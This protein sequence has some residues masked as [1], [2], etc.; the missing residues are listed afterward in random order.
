MLLRRLI[1]LAFTLAVLGTTAWAVDARDDEYE[2]SAAEITR[3][4]Q[5]LQREA[6]RSADD[7]RA[8]TRTDEDVAQDIQDDVEAST[9]AA[10]DGVDVPAS[11]EDDLEAAGIDVD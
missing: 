3:Q 10:L 8:G 5:Q 9:E 6:L 11:V 1:A 4:T 2:R 7:V